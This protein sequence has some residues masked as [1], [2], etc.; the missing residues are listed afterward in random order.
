MRRLRATCIVA[1][2]TLCATVVLTVAAAES[3]SAAA[4]VFHGKGS[5][6]CGA[7]PGDVPGL[8]GFDLA[9]SMV[10]VDAT[11][12]LHVVCW[13]SLPGD[14]SVQQTFIAPVLCRGDEGYA[15]T[16]GRIIAT[17]GGQV[18]ITCIFPAPAG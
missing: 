7:D 15:D 2:A 18:M 4:I 8:P 9:N 14:L 10:V 6:E 5:Y 3:A 11:G 17:K 13:G 12:A 16:T 1:V